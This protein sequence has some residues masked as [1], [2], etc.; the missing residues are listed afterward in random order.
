MRNTGR[1][2]RW[3]TSRSRSTCADAGGKTVFRNDDPGLEPR[4]CR[5]APLLAPG[6]EFAW[7]ND[8][9]AAAGAP[10]AVR[11]KV[12]NARPA[13]AARC[14]ASTLATP[15][16]EQD[17]VSGV[18]AV[19]LRRQPLEG[20]AA[21]AGRSSPSA[22]KGGA[23]SP[24]AAR[25][26]GGCKPGKRARYTI[27]FIGDPRGAPSRSRRR[28]RRLGSE[29]TGGHMTSST[30]R[31]ASTRAQPQLGRRRR[32]APTAA[33]RSPPTSATASTAASAAPRRASRSWT[34]SEQRYR[35]GDLAVSDSLP[36][37]LP[38]R[39]AA[40][41]PLRGRRARLALR[42]SRSAS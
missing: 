34:C 6:E 2:A 38:P 11:A 3:R 28:R 24:P 35:P 14:R 33:R 30:R 17:P 42:C 41:G 5:H 12:G 25:R 37:P 22:T 8:Q 20:R 39:H 10:R 40:G 21:Q 13:P 7:V 18:A 23:S 32:R 9:V 19:G 1:S 4:S 31:S 27:F 15:R 26:S 36:R 16:L 29:R